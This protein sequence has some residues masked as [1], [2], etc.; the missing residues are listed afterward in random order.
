MVVIGLADSIDD[1]VKKNKKRVWDT[2]NVI[3]Q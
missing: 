2:N 3:K 1:E